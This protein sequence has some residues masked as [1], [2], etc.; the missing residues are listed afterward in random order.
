M[1]E[2]FQIAIFPE[3]RYLDK[4]KRHLC[5]PAHFANLRSYETKLR[6][7][8][9]LENCGV[10][11]KVGLQENWFPYDNLL[12]LLRTY[13]DIEWTHYVY[14]SLGSVAI[15]NLIDVTQNI[16]KSQKYVVFINTPDH[17]SMSLP[18][19]HIIVPSR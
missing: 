3:N 4:A 14:A 7:Q 18:H 15:D 1:L 9:H 2:E 16:L 17:R 12:L 11:I 19:G 8:K 13:S 5:D 10:A 6:Y